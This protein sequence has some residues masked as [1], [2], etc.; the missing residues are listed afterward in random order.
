VQLHD[1]LASLLFGRQSVEGFCYAI[2]Y[3]LDHVDF[4]AC[5]GTTII[6][7]L[8]DHATMSAV[9]ASERDA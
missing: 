1:R 9:L 4:V 3:V 5:K 8:Q 7:L 6:A 2:G